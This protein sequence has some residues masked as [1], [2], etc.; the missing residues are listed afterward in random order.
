M[1]TG[2]GLMEGSGGKF[3]KKLGLCLTP[4]MKASET[5][6][7]GALGSIQMKTVELVK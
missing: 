2:N 3:E 6:A 5:G 7:I 4:V 1:D